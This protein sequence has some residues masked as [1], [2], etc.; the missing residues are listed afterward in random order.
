MIQLDK[1]HCGDFRAHDPHAVACSGTA[2]DT[3]EL[4]ARYK[5]HLQTHECG[6]LGGDGITHCQEGFT[7]FSALPKELKVSET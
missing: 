3:S 6:E 7:L 2:P 5:A 4:I 1:K